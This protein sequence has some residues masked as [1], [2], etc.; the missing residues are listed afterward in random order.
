MLL[1]VPILGTL[2]I[3]STPLMAVAGPSFSCWPKSSHPHHF[4]KAVAVHVGADVDLPRNVGF[5]L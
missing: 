1:L 3:Q 5:A 2:N 4:G